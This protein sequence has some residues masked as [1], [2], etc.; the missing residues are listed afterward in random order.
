MR[1]AKFGLRTLMIAVTLLCVYLAYIAYRLSLQGVFATGGDFDL[2]P[3]NPRPIAKEIR[4]R[5]ERLPGHKTGEPFDPAVIPTR[6]QTISIGKNPESWFY[7]V[8]LTDGS[9]TRIGIWVYNWD[10]SGPPRSGATVI[11]YARD[12]WPELV[13]GVA[14]KRRQERR[15]LFN[16]YH[17]IIL[18]IDK[19]MQLEASRAK[20]PFPPS[21]P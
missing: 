12:T 20:Y 6:K 11:L 9:E 18:D 4:D 5:T 16:Q 7:R 3:A 8:K 19:E 2:S 1:R 14:E 10:Y 21:A 15:A 13:S 17:K